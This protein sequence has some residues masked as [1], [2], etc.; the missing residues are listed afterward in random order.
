MAERWVLHIDLDAFFANAEVLRRPELRGQPVIVGGDPDG[1][2]VVASATYAA[3][4]C[5]VRSAMPLA[6]ARRLCP[7]AVFLRG[8]FPYYHDLSHR[9]RAI[10]HDTSPV[11][12]IASIDEAYVE[13]GM[14]SA[15]CRIRGDE[16]IPTWV[17]VR[18]PIPHSAL[19]IPHSIK[20]RLLAD[21]GLTCS[22]G[23]AP[24]KTLAK[25]ASD[26]RKPDGLVVVPQGEA[27][28]AAFLAPLPVGAIPG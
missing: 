6:H 7:D 2:G 3:R 25:I 28:G 14:R 5:G 24:N 21:T 12:E 4:A 27:A 10:L 19:R 15:E 9:F 26:L 11:V 22:I 18:G 16:A 13:C 8:D 17:G 23:V 20:S 1:R